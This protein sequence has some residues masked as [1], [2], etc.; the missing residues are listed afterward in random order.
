MLLVFL[1]LLTCS[2]NKTEPSI[3]VVIIMNDQVNLHMIKMYKSMKTFF[4]S[5]VKASSI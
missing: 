5:Q 1:E 4:L 2:S 3:V